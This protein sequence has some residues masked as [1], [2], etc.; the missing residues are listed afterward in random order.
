MITVQP[1]DWSEQDEK[2]MGK[3]GKL[4]NQLTLRA[5]CLNEDSEPVLLR[6]NDFY[7]MCHMELPM[8][9]GGKIVDWT[10]SKLKKVL[11]QISSVTKSFPIRSSFSRKRTLYYF[12]HHQEYPML[13]LLFS[14]KSD[15]YKFKK[16]VEFPKTYRGIGSFP[17]QVHEAKIGSLRKLMTAMDFDICQWLRIRANKVDNDNKISNLDHEYICKW[18]DVKVLEP[19]IAKTI[20]VNPKL[21][22]FDIECW[23]GMNS[24]KD[25]M[26]F[27]VKD[28]ALHVAYMISVVY[29]EVD[30]PETRKIYVIVMGDCDDIPGFEIIRVNTEVELCDTFAKLIN[31]LDPVLILG[32]NT[33]GFDYDYLDARLKLR[34]RKWVHCSREPGKPTELHNPPAWS[35]SGKGFNKVRYLEMPGR[36]DVDMLKVVRSE[37]KLPDNTMETA[38][39]HFLGKGKSP[40]TPEEMFL[41]YGEFATATKEIKKLTE[42]LQ[43]EIELEEFTYGI[44]EDK[45]R[46]YWCPAMTA[47]GEVDIRPNCSKIVERYIEARKEMTKITEYCGND[48]ILPI[49]I[50]THLGTWTKVRELSNTVGV[51]PTETFL[52]GEQ[53]KC[54]SLIFDRLTKNSI[55]LNNIKVHKMPFEG[56]FV[57]KP[58]PGLHKYVIVLDFKS[59]YPN[60][61]VAYNMCYTT[62]IPPELWPTVPVEDCHIFIWDSE[63]DDGTIVHYEH[64][65][66]K[67]HI[68]KG[69]LPQLCA[70]M[71][72]QRDAVRAVMKTLDKKDPQWAV[73]EA[74]QLA[75]K[76]TGNSFY[77][78][79][80]TGEKGYLPC[81][82]ISSCVTAKGR[83]LIQYCNSYLEEKHN[84]F[85]VYNDTDSTMVKLPFITSRAECKEWGEKLS[86]ELTNE[87]PDSLI[88]EL[89]YC[90]DMFSIAKK[91]YAMKVY[92]DNDD[93]SDDYIQMKGVAPVRRD[94]C[95]MIKK[96]Y[97]NVIETIFDDT[98]TLE[99]SFNKAHE[100]LFG[101]CLSIMQRQV[102]IDDLVMIKGL[103]KDYKSDSYFMKVF[104]DELKRRGKPAE[105]GS[106]L[107][108]LV[109]DTDG[110][111]G[112][113]M[114]LPEQYYEALCTEEQE[115][116]DYMYYVNNGQMI[117]D[118]IFGIAYDG[119]LRHR[120]ETRNDFAAADILN[121]LEKQGLGSHI[122]MA[123]SLYSDETGYLFTTDEI[124]IEWIKSQ[125]ICRCEGQKKK[126]IQALKTRITKLYNISINTARMITGNVTQNPILTASNLFAAK[127]QLCKDIREY[128]PPLK[129][130]P[131][132]IIMS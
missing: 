43:T 109:V 15:L 74:R 94:R 75:L 18:Q 50:F 57:G 71:I 21:I 54:L 32:Y 41:I 53:V 121:V 6:I 95:V 124:L 22:C 48:S 91:M 34:G 108:Y 105:P 36:I 20:V 125:I 33:L 85:I 118:R 69:I 63:E 59:M 122:D 119:I 12:D 116:L 2:I 110:N 60:I 51:T 28:Y 56:G 66:V 76:V 106:K 113:R 16:Y 5:W 9:I 78:F 35:S 83:E 26:I 100:T 55:V 98:L 11:T 87:F 30:R 111:L 4:R 115:T 86:I 102:P 1:Y 46:E 8:K 92:G 39:Q 129:A 3:R 90:V 101:Q 25:P 44:P 38:S 107:K 47:L 93:G 79:L 31:K 19:E 65:F 77:G 13:L 131:Q 24:S 61:I 45:L 80:G 82:E 104:A 17:C 64:R 72:N 27:P 10:R 68:S 14:T 62:L 7:A 99:E 67:E 112:H 128:I 84:G 37:H 117:I 123:R 58:N 29:Q 23:N 96:M 73:L 88:F 81:G 49:D 40:V 103:G 132:F 120:R 70:Y 114:R 52:R 130:A 42:I 89:E 126:A 127:T 97:T